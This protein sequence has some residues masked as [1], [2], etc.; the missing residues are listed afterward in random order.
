MRIIDSK[1]VEKQIINT[2]ALAGGE[3]PASII[4]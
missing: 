1:F 2:F 3:S 4:D